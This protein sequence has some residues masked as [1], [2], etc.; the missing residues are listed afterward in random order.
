MFTH[1]DRAHIAQLC[2]KAGLLQRALEHYTG[3]SV[4]DVSLKYSLFILKRFIISNIITKDKYYVSGHYP[5]ACFCLK[6]HLVL[7][8]TQVS[9]TGFCLH[10]QVK[11]A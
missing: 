5:S 3:K 4:K 11:P 6:C 8:K 2:E 9:E 10:R 1:Y 7:F